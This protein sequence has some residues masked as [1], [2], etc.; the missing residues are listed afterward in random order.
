MRCDTPDMIVTGTVAMV[1]ISSIIFVAIVATYYDDKPP[2]VPDGCAVIDN[3][4]AC[5]NIRQ[6][7][8]VFAGKVM[9]PVC[10]EER[11]CE[12]ELVCYN[13]SHWRY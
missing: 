6:C 2:A 7:V 4:S 11:T 5:S 1:V 8:P 9:V 13:G 10:H 12:K 3:L